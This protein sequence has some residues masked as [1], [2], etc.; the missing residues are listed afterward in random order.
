MTVSTSMWTFLRRALHGEVA[1]PLRYLA[2]ALGGML[3]ALASEGSALIQV[4]AN[5][6]APLGVLTVAGAFVG[7]ALLLL[8]GLRRES[9]AVWRRFYAGLRA[10]ERR[11][12]HQVML[13]VM[14]MLAAD[15]LILFGLLTVATFSRPPSL[16]YRTDVIAFSAVNARLVLAGNNPYTSDTAFRRALIDYPIIGAAPLRQGAFGSEDDL[17]S[18]PRIKAQQHA[19]LTSPQTAAGEF[20]PRTLHSYPALS[21]LLY[22]PLL[23]AG[24]PNILVLHLVLFCGLLVWLVC[25]A[26]IWLRGWGALATSA[27]LLAVAGSLYSE[28]EVVCAAFVLLAWHLRERRWVSA[29]LLGLGCAFKQLC[30]FF[31]PVLLLD[32]L[33]RYGWREALR[34][35]GIASLAFLLPNLPF[36]L[37]NAHAWWVS[38]LLPVS[39][40]QFPWGTGIVAL[41]ITH[42]LPYGPSFLYA[43]LEL[44]TL[45]GALWAQWRWHTV[46]GDAV[47]LLGYVPL[48][49][50][51]HSLPSYF[52][53]APWFALYAASR[54][55]C[56]RRG[57]DSDT[58]DDS[59]RSVVAPTGVGFGAEA[60]I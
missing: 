13:A 34:R 59:A 8:A 60:S 22:V 14:A 24:L 31:V 6:S 33:L 37:M 35:A 20:D 51:T 39:G 30:W 10:R 9:P 7:M 36:L 11:R 29:V 4:G 41:S 18:I 54:V 53:F 19:Y 16:S 28:T 56:A 38:L 48:L 27:G 32:A 26:P 49:F 43:A 3:L 47:V 17:P 55:H 25:Q 2:V 1:V 58:D 57:T 46:Q 44:G 21:F 50:A 52:A 45:L 15:F 12:L 42:L 5:R 23:W 40:P